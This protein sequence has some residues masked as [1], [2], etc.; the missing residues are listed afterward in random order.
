MLFCRS[1]NARPSDG[2]ALS[3]G[4]KGMER[5]AIF[6]RRQF[7]AEAGPQTA[8]AALPGSRSKGQ[9]RLCRRGQALRR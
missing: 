9:V 4:Q 5:P 6:R 8:G 3:A 2:Q 1:E 7:N